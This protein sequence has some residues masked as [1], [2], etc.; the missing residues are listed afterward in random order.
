MTDQSENVRR[1]LF[2]TFIG[3]SIYWMYYIAA[4]AKHDCHDHVLWP[5]LRLILI[6]YDQSEN[7]QAIYQNI[8]YVII[9]FI[10][11]VGRNIYCVILPR[12]KYDYTLSMVNIMINSDRDD[13]INPKIIKH[14]LQTECAASVSKAELHS[15]AFFYH[16]IIAISIYTFR[17]VSSLTNITVAKSRYNVNV[18]R[19][20]RIS[21]WKI[22]K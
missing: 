21:I 9:M 17:F 18:E 13:T 1:K 8:Y 11:F 4:A 3:R 2:I 22:E 10:I 7:V 6:I 16:K 5:I 12:T 20:E 15:T 14:L 19:H